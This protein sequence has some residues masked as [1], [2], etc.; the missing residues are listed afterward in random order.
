MCSLQKKKDFYSISARYLTNNYKAIH[1][2]YRYD[3]E[4]VISLYKDWVYTAYDIF[5]N[6]IFLISRPIA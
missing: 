1:S 6:V 4:G 5:L 2:H 3:F